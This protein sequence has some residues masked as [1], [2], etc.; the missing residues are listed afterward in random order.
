MAVSKKKIEHLV[1]VATTLMLLV[2]VSFG[3]RQI[4][5][6]A[7]TSLEI[8]IKPTLHGTFITPDEVKQT[9]NAY[10]PPTAVGH[11]I[12]EL[13]MFHADSVVTQNPFVKGAV[14]YANVQG[15]MYV[16][17]EQEVPILR[18][19]NNQSEGFYLGMDGQKVPLSLQRTARVLAAT[20]SI[21]ERLSPSDSLVT[22]VAR[23]L[24]VI[25]QYLDNHVF[26]K[27]LAA[28]L[29][30][31]SNGDIVMVTKQEERHDV[32][33]GN[34]QDLDHKFDKLKEFY[35]KVLPI[36][37]WGAYRRIDLRYKDQI[38]AKK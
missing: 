34:A 7:I 18:I 1:Q 28:Q 38:V 19:I 25:A 24:L 6:T 21:T 20:G 5:D 30:V 14:A 32:V 2:L 8:E 22:Q 29:F 4:R 16:E 27:A 12:N 11:K 33:L 37:G 9:I 31:E 23:D 17:I 3:Q 15:H 35:T 26:F 10:F 36:K 13:S